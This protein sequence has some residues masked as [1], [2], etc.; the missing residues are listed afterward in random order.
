VVNGENAA[1][2]RGVTR[3]V[4]EELFSAGA[5]VITLGDHAW[6][7][8]EIMGFIGDTERLLRPA[9]Y[10]PGV[11]GRGCC[12]VE[13]PFG[14]VLVVNLL[15]RV[16]LPP[17]ADCPF[18]TADA[19]LQAE[20]EG[21]AVRIVD[22][23]AEATSE[24]KALG[25][26]L[27]GRV[28]A[29]VGSHTHVATADEAVLPGGTAYITDMGMTGPH[30]SVLGRDKESVLQKFLTGL[31]ARFKVASGGVAC[32]AVLIEADERTGRAEAIRR[33]R[34]EEGKL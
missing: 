7:Q 4:A 27:A 20:A 15:G 13:T 9:N 5:D 16:F 32:E 10:P 12:V 26:Y 34:W 17:V 23:H 6:D 8:K 22:F 11:P 3:A 24:K 19:I 33:I 18:R 28:T 31:P 21:V 2:G 25:W 1:G 14:R 30:D 29:V